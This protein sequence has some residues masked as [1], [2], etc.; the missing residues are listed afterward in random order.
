MKFS[1]FVILSALTAQSS[2]FVVQSPIKR[3][4]TDH[5]S[6]R[7]SGIVIRHPRFDPVIHAVGDPSDVVGA[8]SILSKLP[9]LATPLVA[10]AAVLSALN[11][12]DRIRDEIATTETELQAIRKRLESSQMMINVCSTFLS[13][14]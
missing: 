9:I 7:V 14:S 10:I 3:Q 1:N 6:K 13:I 2:S 8:A 4:Y 5:G 11:Q 12:R